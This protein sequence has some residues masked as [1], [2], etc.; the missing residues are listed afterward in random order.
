VADYKIL[1]GLPNV[2][3]TNIYL[4]GVDGSA[5][6]GNSEVA[7][8]IDM[9]MAMAP[10]LLQVLVYEGTTPNDILNRMATDNAARQLSSSWGFGPV[11]D[12]VREQIYQQFAAQGQTM[13]QASGDDGA[14]NNGIFP[15]SD[16]PNLTIVGGT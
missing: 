16:D 12:P 5:G 8:D 13:F 4:D 2:P 14:Y 1:A 9:A 15:P 10:G 3:I 11:N 7:L 6:T